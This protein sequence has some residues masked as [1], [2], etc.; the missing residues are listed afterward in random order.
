MVRIKREVLWNRQR[1]NDVFNAFL[2]TLKF[3]NASGLFESFSWT[4]CEKALPDGSK[5][6]DGIVMDATVIEI[7]GKITLSSHPKSAIEF[8]RWIPE[9]T[10][11]HANS[12]IV[13]FA[14]AIFVN[15]KPNDGNI[16]FN[17]PLQQSLWAKPI[18]LENVSKANHSRWTWIIWHVIPF[19]IIIHSAEINRKSK[20]WWRRRKRRWYSNTPEE[21]SCEIQ[22]FGVC[23]QERFTCLQSDLLQ[24]FNSWRDIAQFGFDHSLQNSDSKTQAFCELWTYSRRKRCECLSFM[25]KKIVWSSEKERRPIILSTANVYSLFESAS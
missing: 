19:E 2:M 1:A 13:K 14:E 20:I 17:F 18:A 12:K 11:R 16:I 15:V 7:L 10:V 23:R 6:L 8:F 4:N 22:F 21:S 9:K 5:R 24:W 3:H 25:L